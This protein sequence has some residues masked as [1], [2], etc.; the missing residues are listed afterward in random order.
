MAT[1]CQLFLQK[2]SIVDVW[3][4]FKYASVNMLNFHLTFLRK[5]LMIK[6]DES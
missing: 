6:F 5:A 3:L 1:S 4:G 2:G